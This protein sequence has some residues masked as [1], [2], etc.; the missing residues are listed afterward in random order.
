MLS[1]K[2]IPVLAILF[3]L[4][5]TSCFAQKNQEKLLTTILDSS[6]EA[7]QGGDYRTIDILAYSSQESEDPKDFYAS[8]LDYYLGAGAGETLEDFIVK[9]GNSIVPVLLKKKGSPLNCRK[10]YQQICTESVE[11]RNERINR[12]IKEIQNLSGNRND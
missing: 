1:N 9:E 4:F 3:L 2:K 6:L 12:L 5:F 11:H 8:L 7:V 10:E